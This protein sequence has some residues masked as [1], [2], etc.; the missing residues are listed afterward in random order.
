MWHG[1][2]S[3]MVRIWVLSGMGWWVMGV[4]ADMMAS[5]RSLSWL[6]SG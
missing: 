2:R 3:G 1:E 5:G 6:V 4:G